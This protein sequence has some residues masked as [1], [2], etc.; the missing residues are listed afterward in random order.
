[1]LHIAPGESFCSGMLRKQTKSQKGIGSHASDSYGLS[2]K[3]SSSVTFVGAIEAQLC[4]HCHAFASLN[5][6]YAYS[7]F[8]VSVW[9][10]VWYNT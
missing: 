5:A 8:I 1:M 10:T 6:I 9:Y 7:Y 4:T 2:A 3:Q